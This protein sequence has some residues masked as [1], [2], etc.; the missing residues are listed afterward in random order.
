MRVAESLKIKLVGP[1]KEKA[2]GKETE[3]VPAYIAY[4]KGRS[5]LREGT[6]KS[7][8]LAREQFQA[9]IKADAS[10]AKAYSGLADAT[11]LLGD[12]LFSPV[13]AALDEAAG[14]VK[15]ALSLDPQ[16]A[17]ARVSLGVLHLFD[18]K[19]DEGERELRMALETNPSYATGHHWYSMCMELFGRKDEALHQALIAE[20]LD[21]LSPRVALTVFYRLIHHGK[22]DE[23]K[24]M[25]RKLEEIDRSSPLVDEAQMVHSFAM[26]DWDA[27]LVP[28]R[29]M[30]DSDPNDPYLDMDLAYIYAVTGKKEEAMKIVEKLKNIPEEQRVRGQLLA[31]VYVGLGDIDGALDWIDYGISQKEFFISWTRGDPLFAPVRKTQRYWDLVKSAG[32]PVG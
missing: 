25:I 18:Y 19:F 7:V 13:P 26:K 4:L 29:R 10:Y 15:K 3:S 17:E 28:L 30:M 6:E 16:L 5:F 14:Y 20:E 31:L 32:L 9:A 27:A 12:L 11:V 24:K 2:Q 21:P 8:H 22:L 23:A 1:T